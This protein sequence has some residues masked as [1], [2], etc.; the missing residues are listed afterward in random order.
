[1]TQKSETGKLGE[2]LACEY[3]VNNKYKVI[4]RN[5]RRPWG[6]LDIIAKDSR[7]VLVFVE[8][9]TMKKYDNS[10]NNAAIAEYDESFK[11]NPAILRYARHKI[12]YRDLSQILPEENLTAAKLKKLKRTAELYANTNP[13]LVD[14]NKGYRIDLLAITINDN[15]HS[16]KHFENIN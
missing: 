16:L 6:E 10:A 2:D 12:G 3:L 14:D 13:N 4:E 9:K 11:N 8:V 1:M 15:N 5:F 7:G